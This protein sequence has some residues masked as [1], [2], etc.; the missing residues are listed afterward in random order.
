[1]DE[2]LLG[3]LD[4]LLELKNMDLRDF[5]TDKYEKKT[6]KVIKSIYF[7]GDQSDIQGT[8]AQTFV[9]KIH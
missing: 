5:I 1:M 4:K 2:I 9:T 6:A 3:Q 8:Q 7:E